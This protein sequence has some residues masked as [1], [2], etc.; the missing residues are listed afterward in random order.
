MSVAVVGFVKYPRYTYAYPSLTGSLCLVD[1]IELVPEEI[2]TGEFLLEEEVIDERYERLD[3]WKLIGIAYG[4]ERSLY[5]DS[6]DRLWF[7]YPDNTACKVLDE[8][9]NQIYSNLH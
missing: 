2:I 1:S 9:G 8:Q 4:G 3:D 7:V 6:L 5:V